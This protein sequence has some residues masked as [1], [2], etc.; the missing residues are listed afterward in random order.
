LAAPENVFYFGW[1][2]ASEAGKSPV[3]AMVKPCDRFTA[4][5]RP[6]IVKDLHPTNCV[7]IYP[8]SR[9][10]RNTFPRAM[11]RSAGLFRSRGNSP[12]HRRK[13]DHEQRAVD[14]YSPARAHSIAVLHGSTDSRR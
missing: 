7:L 3:A 4:V 14:R 2:T 1:T 8:H 10:S 9:R 12:A 11:A 5:L 13:M 6:G